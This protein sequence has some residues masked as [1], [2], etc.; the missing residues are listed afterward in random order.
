MANSTITKLPG[1][2]AIYPEWEIYS[3]EFLTIESYWDISFEVDLPAQF[4][5]SRFDVSA[6]LK[7]PGSSVT[8]RCR[9]YSDIDRTIVIQEKTYTQSTASATHSFSFTGLSLNVDAVYFNIDIIDSDLT[10]G[11]QVKIDSTSTTIDIPSLSVGATPASLYTGENVTLTFTNRISQDLTVQLLYNNTPIYTTT[12]T[13]DTKVITCDSNLFTTAG[14]TGNSMSIKARAFDQLGRTSNDATFT[15]NKPAGGSVSLIAPKNTTAS[16][17]NTI[18]FSWSY[19]GDGTLTTTE[20]QWSTD[21]ATW[22]ALTTVTGG[23]TG[24]PAPAYKFP[25][26]TIYWRARATNSYGKTGNYS[27][28]AS[29]TVS[30]PALSIGVTPASLFAGNSVLLSFTNRLNQS[31]TVKF[32]YNTTLLY[33]TTANSD[34]LNVAC[35]ESWFTTAGIQGNSMNVKVIASD[36]LGRTSSDVS[37][38][39]QRPTSGTVTTIAPKNISKDG[40]GEIPF[41]WSYSGDGTLTKTELQ[42]STDNATWQALRTINNSGTTW[43]AP[44]IKFPSGTIYWRASCTNS[45]GKTSEYPASGTSFTVYYDAV[46]QVV[47]TGSPTSGIINAANNRQFSATLE[48]SGPVYSPFTVNSATFYWRSGQSGDFTPVAMTPNGQTASVTIAGGTFPSGIIQWYAEATDNTGRTTE[49]SVF[50]LTALNAEI[51]ATPISPVNTVESGSGPI[52]FRWSYGSIDG[53]PQS[54]ADLRFSTDDETWGSPLHIVGSDAFYTAPA[55]TISGGTVY[56]Q[57]R[58]YNGSGNDGPWSASASFICYA[59]P[60]ITSVS[61]NNAPFCTVSWQVEDQ[62][63][64]KVEIDGK[65]YGPYFGED[66]RSFVA[67]EPLSDGLHTVRVAAQNEYG[68]WSE[69]ASAQIF[70]SNQSSG[71]VAISVD[72]G[73]GANTI[74]IT[75]STHTGV[76]LI[77][78]NGKLIAKTTASVFVDRTFTGTAEYYCIQTLSG[79]NYRKSNTVAIN[80]TVDC[81][82]IALLGG[83]EFIP[84]GLSDNSEQEITITRRR[85]TVKTYYSGAKYPAVESGEQQELSTSF[86]TFWIDCNAEGAD[87][88]EALLGF[89]VILKLPYGHVIIG[90]LDTLPGVD[91]SWRRAY[92]ISVE[93]MEWSDF[94]D[95][96]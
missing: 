75:A 16:G 26:G 84:L 55:G 24:W 47:P 90:V 59:A 38:S 56:W 95:V 69:W 23:N 36:S 71:S 17:D 53:T 65:L 49:T 80:N 28:G 67:K 87:A 21:N 19:S 92:T 62:V 60:I 33:T 32:L 8:W 82:I 77:Y 11:Y 29:F 86:G 39:L 10:S 89:P 51:E 40:A 48:A 5:V 12:A 41:S 61:G 66:A 76:F 85:Q 35:P 94:I 7:Q 3:G 73:T 9:L 18:A 50:T 46:S 57:V 30:F 15:L 37:F 27:S 4:S 13:T 68:L 74:E 44:A 70:V 6:N 14:V 78:R 64:Y 72:A 91:S 96:S 43:K 83:G 93:Q 79:G 1:R 22:Q 52:T 42:W 2:Y 54:A 31:L 20:L 45:Y 25:S 81:P 88:L 34:T 58:A 63:T